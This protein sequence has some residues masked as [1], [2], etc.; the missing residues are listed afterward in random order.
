MLRSHDRIDKPETRVI[1]VLRSAQN[2]LS[3]VTA[4]QRSF[5]GRRSGGAARG[6]YGRDG[7]GDPSER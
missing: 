6:V 7:E 5:Y 3:I 2:S 4:Q 1:A